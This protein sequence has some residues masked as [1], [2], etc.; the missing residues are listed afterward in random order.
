MTIPKTKYRNP[1]DNPWGQCTL[2][3]PGAHYYGWMIFAQCEDG[4][5]AIIKSD[6]EGLCGFWFRED[7]QEFILKKATKSGT[8]YKFIGEYTKF[9]SGKYRFKGKTVEMKL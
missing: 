2:L 9:K 1:A 8:I 5:F 4:V 3:V 7:R 6:F